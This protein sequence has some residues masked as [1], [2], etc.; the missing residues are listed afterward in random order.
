MTTWKTAAA[1]HYWSKYRP[2]QETPIS[3]FTLAG[4]WTSQKFLGSMEGAVLGGKLAAEVVS[5]K[6]KGMK[7]AGLKK[8]NADIVSESST[9]SN[10]GWKRAQKMEDESPVVFGA[11]FVMDETD[12]AQLRVIDPEQLKELDGR[13]QA[14]KDAVK[15]AT[16]NRTGTPAR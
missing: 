16:A 13:S 4:D 15:E 1:V 8:I 9:F 7:T 5:A 12:E 10:Q 2:S 3:N 11:G 14:T 6:A